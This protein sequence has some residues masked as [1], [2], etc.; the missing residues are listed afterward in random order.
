VKFSDGQKKQNPRRGP[1]AR[2]VHAEMKVTTAIPEI[3][4]THVTVVNTMK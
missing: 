2:L 4:E 1:P 3:K